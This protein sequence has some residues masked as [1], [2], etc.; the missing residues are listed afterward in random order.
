MYLIVKY[1]RKNVNTIFYMFKTEGK[2]KHLTYIK[3]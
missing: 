1:T 3:M 2:E